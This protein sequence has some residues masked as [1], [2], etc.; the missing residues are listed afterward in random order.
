MLGSGSKFYLQPR[1]SGLA[2][3]P[4]ASFPELDWGPPGLFRSVRGYNQNPPLFAG[5]A[6][7]AGAGRAHSMG[8]VV[9]GAGM[10]RQTLPGFANAKTHVCVPLSHIG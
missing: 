1:G 10:A 6:H 8:P 7:S 4:Q 5:P 9:H 2:R 3:A